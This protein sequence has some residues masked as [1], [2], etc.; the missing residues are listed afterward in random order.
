M[1]FVPDFVMRHHSKL[2]IIVAMGYYYCLGK[3]NRIGKSTHGDDGD[4]VRADLVV[5][6]VFSL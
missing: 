2:I 3:F 1:A 6:A 5:A 4:E